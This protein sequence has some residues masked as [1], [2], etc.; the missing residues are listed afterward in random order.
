MSLTPNGPDPGSSA[1]S[2]LDTDP[3]LQ[4]ERTALGWRRTGLAGVALV[5]VF[6]RARIERFDRMA[7][8]LVALSAT[9]MLALLWV[10]YHGS[11]RRDGRVPAGMAGLIVTIALAQLAAVA[12][13]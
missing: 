12:L 3:G 7:M 13:D 4:R 9:V 5:G 8:M 11:V 2:D 10:C 1:W 6:V